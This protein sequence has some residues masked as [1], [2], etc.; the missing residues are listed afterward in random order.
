[1]P[2]VEI[3]DPERVFGR[4]R[5]VPVLAF[6]IPANDARDAYVIYDLSSPPV[7]RFIQPVPCESDLVVET[8]GRQLAAVDEPL[9]LTLRPRP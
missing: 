7:H 1:L 8:A 9:Y 2:S 6:A 5:L 4:Y 3:S